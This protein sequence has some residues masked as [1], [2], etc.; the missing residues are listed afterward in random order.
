MKR[1]VHQ[2]LRDEESNHDL[3]AIIGIGGGLVL[4]ALAV[5]NTF[6]AR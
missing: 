6:L 5:L 2:L 1:F 4:L 3:L